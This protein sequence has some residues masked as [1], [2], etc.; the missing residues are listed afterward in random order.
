KAGWYFIRAVA[1]TPDNRI[2][3]AERP[4]R[5]TLPADTFENLFMNIVE[6]STDRPEKE[7]VCQ[8]DVSGAAAEEGIDRVDM[9]VVTYDGKIV[10]MRT[11]RTPN[12][13]AFSGGDNNTPCP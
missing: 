2:Q 5:I 9:F 13:C 7:L 6:P 1:H 12:Y 3:V 11:E 4:L 8:A 10:H